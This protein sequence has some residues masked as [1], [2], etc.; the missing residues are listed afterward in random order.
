MSALVDESRLRAWLAATL[1]AADDFSLERHQAGHS[2]ETFFLRWGGRDLVLRR[3]P[4]GAFL[5][6]AHD[7]LREH[8]ILAALADTPVRAPRPVA[9]CEDADVLGAPF[10]LMEK[11]EGFVVRNALPPALDDAPTRRRLGFELVDALA[12]IHNLSWEGTPLA[13]LGKPEGYLERQVKRWTGQME[14]TLPWTEKKRPVPELR[15]AGAW[16]AAHVPKSPRTTLV[17]GDS[18]LDNVVFSPEGRLVA[19]LDWEMSTLGDPLA[20]LGWML[21][22]WRERGDPPALPFE[23]RVTEAPGFATR[24]ELIERYEAATGIKAAHLPFYRALATWKLAILL[25][26]SYAR[27]LQ[28]ATDDPFFARMETGVPALARRALSFRAP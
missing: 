3:P 24:S 26:G 5:P 15:E 23:P 12:E 11:V 10:Y 25:E 17:H 19:V 9:A 4:A 14:M 18:K 27:H 20:D 8:R 2:N 16:L 6:T 1:G 13:Q 22:F 7:V 28:G 21:S